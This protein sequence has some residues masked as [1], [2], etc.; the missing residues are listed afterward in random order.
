MVLVLLLL[1]LAVFSFSFLFHFPTRTCMKIYSIVDTVFLLTKKIPSTYL[2]T[3]CRAGDPGG[4]SVL[5]AY[6]WQRKSAMGGSTDSIACFCTSAD[7]KRRWYVVNSR[8][9]VCSNSLPHSLLRSGSFNSHS[10][11][12]PPQSFAQAVLTLV[13]P[14]LPSPPLPSRC[15][16]LPE[17]LGRMAGEVSGRQSHPLP[18]PAV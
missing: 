4:G 6:S 11:P 15:S 16:V 12:P 8:I 7:G 2:S 1:F 3:P 9:W 18:P 17:Q 5:D 14:P 13:L 10:P